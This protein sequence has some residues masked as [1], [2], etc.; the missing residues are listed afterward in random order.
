[1]PSRE[2]DKSDNKFIAN[3]SKGVLYPGD[4]P[5]PERSAPSIEVTD[6]GDGES[7]WGIGPPYNTGY[8]FKAEDSVMSDNDAVTSMAK[9]QVV[10]RINIELSELTDR[11]NRL[12][13]H[14]DSSGFKT[15]SLKQQHSMNEQY[16]AMRKYRTELN[17][18]IELC[19]DEG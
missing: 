13:F 5:Y 18:R 2:L 3:P 12:Q 14:M 19:W 6:I 15:Y 10:D 17:R 4:T 7:V 8:I 1:M 16:T 9:K 11:L